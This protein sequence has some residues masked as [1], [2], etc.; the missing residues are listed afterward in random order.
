MKKAQVNYK[1][2]FDVIPE[3]QMIEE[4]EQEHEAELLSMIE[5]DKLNYI[6]SIVLGLNDAW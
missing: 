4:Q 3:A 2:V 6:G 1:D 5:E